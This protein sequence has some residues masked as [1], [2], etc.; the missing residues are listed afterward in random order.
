M[1]WACVTES[2]ATAMLSR[3]RA[4][5]RTFKGHRDPWKDEGFVSTWPGAALYTHYHLQRAKA[6]VPPH[7]IWLHPQ[8]APGLL[9]LAARVSDA[10]LSPASTVRARSPSQLCLSSS[11]SSGRKNRPSGPRLFTPNALLPTPPAITT[12]PA[13][14]ALKVQISPRSWRILIGF[15]LVP[16]F[17]PKG[18]RS[19]CVRNQA[20]EFLPA[21]GT[22]KLFTEVKAGFF[23]FL[24]LRPPAFLPSHLAELW[25]EGEEKVKAPARRGR[26][27]SGSL[28]VRCSR[29][30]GG[31]WRLAE[32]AGSVAAAG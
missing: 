7:P 13:T 1:A 32:G 31:K 29:S 3:Q 18:L 10:F 11:V 9:T 21:A 22:P 4:G 16:P 27:P 19:F 6:L 20:C 30:V 24:T 12:L 8:G 2:Q 28:S 26:F 23:F 25:R 14:E 15:V 5:K 17:G